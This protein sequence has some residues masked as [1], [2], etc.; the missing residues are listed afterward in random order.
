MNKLESIFENIK[1]VGKAKKTFVKNVKDLAEN[2]KDVMIEHS[3]HEIGKLKLHKISSHRSGDW[4][5]EL[6]CLG[7]G[8]RDL[9]EAETNPG[10]YYFAQ[11]FNQETFYAGYDDCIYF[12]D[13]LKQYFEEDAQKMLNNSS[14]K[15]NTYNS[16]FEMFSKIGKEEK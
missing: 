16:F 5:W 2:I 15:I 6:W 9:L 7:A 3:I 14:E 1:R 13:Y 12:M 8:E 11:D 10:S 4:K